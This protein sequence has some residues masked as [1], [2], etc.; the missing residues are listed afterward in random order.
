MLKNAYLLAIVAVHTAENEPSKVNF[1]R[2]PPSP[3]GPSEVPR[4]HGRRRARAA[5]RRGRRNQ[6]LQT[7]R[8]RLYG[9][10]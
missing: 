1:R 6:Q 8:S 3:A 9:Q 5:R 2:C 4:R 7:A 10:L